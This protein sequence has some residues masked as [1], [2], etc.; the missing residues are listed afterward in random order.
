MIEIYRKIFALLDRRERKRFILLMGV[1]IVIAL[2]ELLGISAVLGLLTVLAEPDRILETPILRWIYDAA[3]FESIFAFQVALTFG[4]L[5]VVVGG[6]VTKAGGTYA[7][8]RYSEMRGYAIS[9]R[10]L[11]SYLNLPYDWFLR[12]N[13]AELGKNILVESVAFVGMVLAP[14]LRILSSFLTAAAILV[15]MIAVNPL[16]APLAGLVIGVSYALVY[17]RLRSILA[18]LGHDLVAANTERFRLAQEATAGIKEVKLLGLENSYI[19]RFEAPARRAARASA[20]N[21]ALAEMPRFALEAITLSV[22]LSL[23][24]ILLFRTGGDIVSVVPLMGVFAFATLRLLPAL[25]QIYHAL[26]TLKFGRAVLDHLY[27]EYTSAIVDASLR[28]ACE[29]SDGVLPLGQVLSLE[30]VRYSYPM[31]ER[32]ALCDVS[33]SIPA[34][35]TVG[36]VGGTGAGKTT[37]VDLVLGLLD[38]DSGTIRVDGTILNQVTLRSWQRT[39]G[40]VPQTIYLTDDT[41]AANIAFGVPP[42]QI[43]LA[44]VERAARLAALHEFVVNEL[45]GGYK[46]F[47][48]ERGIRLSGGQRQRI[49]IARALYHD[50]S[51]IIFDE[52]TSALDNLTERSVMDAVTNMR[53]EKTIILIAHRLSTIRNCDV[54]YFMER[55]GVTGYGTYDELVAKNETFRR[56]AVGG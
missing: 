13:S 56:M 10:L 9:C 20:L 47:V 3:N 52:A 7:I 19:R 4:T 38:P 42:E 18:R 51:L 35:T 36:I 15:F 14:A 31:A 43:D 39:L 30:A 21:N 2:S 11:G 8:I 45:P 46:A 29:S 53:H 6:L 16:I 32:M 22:L 34:R 1:M 48:G 49:G 50:P 40:Y 26:A 55:G 33:I 54:I 17:F 37:L 12:R 25:Q 27:T 28:P 23:I 44:K 41:V 24:L 5:A